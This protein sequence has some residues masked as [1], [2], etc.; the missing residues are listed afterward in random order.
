MTTS[1]DTTIQLTVRKQLCIAGS[2]TTTAIESNG[3]GLVVV[4]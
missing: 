4:R 1:S 3:R 2:A